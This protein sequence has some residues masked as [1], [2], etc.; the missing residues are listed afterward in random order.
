MNLCGGVLML[1]LAC[2]RHC[3]ACIVPV[4][5]LAF[6]YVPAVSRAHLFSPLHVTTCSAE[7]DLRVG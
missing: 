7:Y 3:Y 4:S 6:Q 5:L 1:L 2:T